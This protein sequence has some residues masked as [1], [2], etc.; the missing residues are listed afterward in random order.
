LST[1]GGTAA[2]FD[3]HA[4]DVVFTNPRTSL[5][6]LF[7]GYLEKMIKMKDMAPSP[8][9]TY[10]EF[11]TGWG[12]TLAAFMLAA[13]RVASAHGFH[14]A[15]FRVFAFD[16][17]E[18]LPPS[19]HPADRHGQ[20]GKGAMA[21]SVEVIRQKMET[22]P[23]AKR[24]PATYTKGYFKQSLTDALIDD[25]KALPPSIVTID[26]D[27]Y[28]STLEALLWLDRFIVS[29]ALIYFD[30][31][32]AFH[33]HPDYGQIRAIRDFC[34]RDVNGSLISFDTF[35]EAGKCFIYCRKTFEY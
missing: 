29:G 4:M 1:I 25:L 10:Y 33:G 12:G 16:S 34:A 2:S 23:F 26:V 22:H 31:V 9:G 11:G 6:R 35:G 32:W 27:Y 5:V 17:F 7:S 18:G 28:T 24:V 13:E 8:F 3:D 15:D 14:P 21:N 30:D 20:W 19:D